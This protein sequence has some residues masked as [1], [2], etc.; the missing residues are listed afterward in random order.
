[1]SFI[2]SVTDVNSGIREPFSALPAEESLDDVPVR[3]ATETSI[4]ND[5]RTELGFGIFLRAIRA[6]A[7]HVR[8]KKAR[9]WPTRGPSPSGISFHPHEGE[10]V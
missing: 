2:L 5:F 4:A 3:L 9:L 7:S 10:P 6:I 8:G 1:M